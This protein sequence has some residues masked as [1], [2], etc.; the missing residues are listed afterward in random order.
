MRVASIGVV[1]WFLTTSLG[2]SSVLREK[3]FVHERLHFRLRPPNGWH[4]ANEGLTRNEPVE[5]W[6]DNEYGPRIQIFSFPFDLATPANLDEAQMELSRT[7]KEQFPGLKIVDEQKLSHQ[8]NP[9]IEVMATLQIEDT[10]YHVIQRCLF[11]EGRI[12]IITCASFESTFLS[13]L[14][15]FRA[16]LNSVEVLGD[17]Y[18]PDFAGERSGHLVQPTTFGWVAGGLALLGLVLRRVSSTRLGQTRP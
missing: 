9:A 6:K 16:C 4:L 1:L 11:A 3:P 15:V 12:Y 13:D 7:L 8:G 5:F 18:D 17:I 10:Y 14:P 2:L